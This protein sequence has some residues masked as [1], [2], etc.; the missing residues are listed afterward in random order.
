[1]RTIPLL[2]RSLVVG[3]ERLSVEISPLGGQMGRAWDQE[4]SQRPQRGFSGLSRGT[5]YQCIARVFARRPQRL[6]D[7]LSFKRHAPPACRGIKV[8]HREPSHKLRSEAI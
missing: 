3:C 1:M 8:A 4:Q 2:L 5:S 7:L 6:A